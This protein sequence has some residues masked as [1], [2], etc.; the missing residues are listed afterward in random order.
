MEA[1]TF[2]NTDEVENPFKFE[3]LAL[4]TLPDGPASRFLS[5]ATPIRGVHPSPRFTYGGS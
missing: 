4:R 5:I 2:C 3:H 1:R